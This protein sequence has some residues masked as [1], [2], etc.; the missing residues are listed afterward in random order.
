MALTRLDETQLV[1]SKHSNA[2]LV[3]GACQYPATPKRQRGLVLHC[4]RWLCYNCGYPHTD[5]L[6]G[7]LSI[8]VR[9]DNAPFLTDTP[10]VWWHGTILNPWEPP[11]NRYVHIGTKYAA[12]Q[13]TRDNVTRFLYRVQ[14]KEHVRY[15]PGFYADENCWPIVTSHTPDHYTAYRYINRVESPGSVSVLVPF[16][17][18]DILDCEA[19]PRLS[20]KVLDEL[21]GVAPC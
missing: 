19:Y 17:A 6:G 20:C 18:L 13:I 12:K 21:E 11:E 4:A 7:S 10:R 1:I 2:V 5:T 14:L 15:A 3:C 8:Q 16:G 9:R